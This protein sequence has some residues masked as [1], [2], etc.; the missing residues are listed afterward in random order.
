MKIAMIGARGGG[1]I[2][3]HINELSRQLE[4]R[5][6][7][8]ALIS[9]RHLSPPLALARYVK[10]LAAGYDIVHIHGDYDV[11]GLIAGLLATKALGGGTV[12]TTH[13]TGSRYWRP[14]KRWGAL[15]KDSAKR[16]DVIISV[17]EYVRRRLAQVLGENPPK[18]H[19]IYNGVDTR[20]FSPAEDSSEAKREL[21]VSGK[22]VLLYLGRLAP[23]K[24]ISYLL[25]A[26]PSL[27]NEIRNVMLLVG[28]RGEMEGDLRREAVELGVSDVVE[29]RG[30]VPQELLVSYYG[31]SD[32]VVV[33]SVIEAMGIVPLEAMSMKRPVVGARTGGIPELLTNGRTG[34]LVPPRDPEAIA[35][36]VKTLHENRELAAQLGENGRMIVEKRFSWERIAQET[37]EAYADALSG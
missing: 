30:F 8:V 7:S 3:T 4:L 19:T 9:P 12:F 20:F 17:S 34:F 2:A 28:G 15:W 36:A 31:A 27:K 14:G 5:G 25:R 33:P 29:F 13:G 22:Y 24:G 10:K 23:S 11:P 21:G 37:L 32:V 1:G 18:H 26:M 6:N 16:V 35:N